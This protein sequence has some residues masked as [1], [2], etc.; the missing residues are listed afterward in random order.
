MNV[1]L[2]GTSRGIY[3]IHPNSTLTLPYVECESGGSFLQ[4]LPRC[5]E[6]QPT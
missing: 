6:E 2:R 5:M 1:P 4:V 3:Q